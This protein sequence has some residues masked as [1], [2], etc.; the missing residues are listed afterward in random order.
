MVERFNPKVVPDH[1]VGY[2][3][4]GQFVGTRVFP[5]EGLPRSR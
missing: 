4:K 3:E 5:M 2:T 1:V